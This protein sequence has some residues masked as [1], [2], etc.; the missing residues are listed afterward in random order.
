MQ[1]HAKS[2]EKESGGVRPR[3]HKK[4]KSEIGRLPSMTNIAPERK[5]SIRIRGARQKMRLYSTNT[6]NV[7]D[8]RTLKVKKAKIL[9]IIENKAHHQF[10]KL[11]IITKGAVIKTDAGNAR[12]TSRP[13]QC[14][15]VEAVLVSK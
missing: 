8:P 5:A 4:K 6:A 14:G 11:K 9:D 2:L 15:V 1:Y 10:A 3:H 12:V 7:L 13:G